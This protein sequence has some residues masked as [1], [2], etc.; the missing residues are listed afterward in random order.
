VGNFILETISPT[1]FFPGDLDT[2]GS[3]IA[4]G[5]LLYVVTSIDPAN[6]WLF[7]EGLDPNTQR[8]ISHSYPAPGNYTAALGRGVAG[9]TC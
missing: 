9:D 8:P 7:G 2:F 6:N 5:P 4:I 1:F 3:P